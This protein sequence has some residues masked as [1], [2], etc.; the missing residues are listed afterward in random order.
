MASSS[1]LAQEGGS[2][3]D[4]I[5]D[6][7]GSSESESGT[8]GTTASHVDQAVQDL[9][10]EINVLREELGVYDYPAE[11]ER[12][13][14]RAPVHIYVKS[15]E[16][17]TKLSAVQRK[18]GVPA[19]EVG[20]IPFKEIEPEDV[21]ANVAYIL[22]EVRKIKAQMVIEREIEPAPLAG[23]KTASSVYKSLADAS[24]LL[25]GLR[26]RPLTPDDMFR[27][28]GYVLDEMELIAAKL[29]VPLDFELPEISG[30]KRP[31]DVA[32]QV[33]RATYKVINLQTRLGMDASG[34]PGLTLVRVTPSEVYDA[35]NML[36]AE[37]ARIK[38]HLDINVP[39]D[40]DGTEPR[41]KKPEDTFAVVLVIVR[42]L[43]VMSRAAVS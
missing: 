4:A 25:D 8:S 18:F 27:N 34:V 29:K 1:A 7:F 35:T 5:S 40:D 17:L 15:L 10:A 31:V 2:W 22:R 14:D 3:R 13:D 26:G 39:R 38:L 33:L 23:G 11:A 16:V 28:A 9:I 6:W 36:L 19:A 20:R 24:F 37:M 12:Q 43:D 41:G 32:Q 30:A 21:L 42:N